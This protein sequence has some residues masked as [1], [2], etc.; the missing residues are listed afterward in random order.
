MCAV[1]RPELKRDFSGKGPASVSFALSA[2]FSQAE[3]DCGCALRFACRAEG[4]GAI[5]KWAHVSHDGCGMWG[6]RETLKE[7]C[8]PTAQVKAKPG[9]RLKCMRRRTRR[10]GCTREVD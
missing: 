10:E 5:W 7:N 3:I 6:G 4:Q 1:S 8:R 9:K 2:S